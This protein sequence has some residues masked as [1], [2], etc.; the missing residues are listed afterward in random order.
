MIALLKLHAGTAHGVLDGQPAQA[1]PKLE[2]LPRPS[3]SLD[4]TEAEW[5]FKKEQWT[6]YISQT[7][8]TEATKCQQLKAACDE[9]LLRR[10]YDAGSMQ[11]YNTEDLLLDRIKT[12]A[13]RMTH[14]TLHIQNL[15]SMCQDPDEG[16]RS[17][18]SRLVGTADLCNY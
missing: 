10:V 12:L 3:L 2:K 13:V 16:I 1:T 18:C 15:W 5:N 4:M 7:Q 6:A 9:Q 8:T 17:F 14:K 11:T